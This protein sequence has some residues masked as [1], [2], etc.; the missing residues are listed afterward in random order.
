MYSVD[1]PSFDQPLDTAV[2]FAQQGVSLEPG[3]QLCHLIL[4]Y[5]SYLA[6]DS[7]VFNQEIETAL[8]L[9]P[10]SPYTVGTAGYFHVMRGEFERGLPLLDRAIHMNPC[11]PSWF[12]GAYVIA[13]LRQGDYDH[14][15]QE[16]QNHHPYR[17]FWLPVAYGAVLGLLGRIDEAKS[18][19][20]QVEESK[21]DF[22]SRARELLRRTLKDDSISDS[23]IEGLRRA[24]L[25]VGEGTSL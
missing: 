12:H 7:E 24:G 2:R 22:A 9:N 14:A 3:S 6:E 4:A 21:P 1:A 15:L 13:H 23:L 8:N 25:A 17:S 20:D 18:H 10:N 19:L 11:H 5:A 16:L